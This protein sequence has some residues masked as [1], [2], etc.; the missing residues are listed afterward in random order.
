MNP[1][2]RVLFVPGFMQRGSAWAP[3]AELLPDRYP[4]TLLDHREHSF[5]GRLRE[6][7][8][9]GEGAVLCGYSLGGRLAVHAALRDPSFYAGLITVGASAGIDEP[10]ARAERARAD[11]KI[12]AWMETA[13]IEDIVAVWERQPLFADQSDPLVENQREGRVSHDPRE[14]ALVLRTAGQGTLDPVWHELWEI[15]LPWLALAGA[16]DERYS[17][18][19][20]RIAR[21]ARNARAEVVPDAGHAAHLQQPAAVAELIAEFLDETGKRV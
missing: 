7:A 19:A 12:A 9:A 11:E 4:S 6:I 8:D 18:A 10:A 5:E 1:T 17:A 13:A 21:E 2:T 15:R 3:V 16:R 14:L 20:R